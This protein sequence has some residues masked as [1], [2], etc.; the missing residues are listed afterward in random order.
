MR[1]TK[2]PVP[3]HAVI[4]G[5]GKTCASH[6][7]RNV[8]EAGLGRE[9]GL[10]TTRHAYLGGDVLPPPAWPGWREQLDQ[11]LERMR[12]AG[13]SAVVLTLPLFALGSAALAGLTF[14]TVVLTGC[15]DAV[16]AGE[17]AQ[18][19]ETQEGWWVCNIDDPICGRSF[20]ADSR[21]R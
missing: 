19:L 15:G 4:G 14:E 12:Q 10:I 17:V 1:W 9:Y 18:F 3:L 20:R 8:L 16:E 5:A 7:I 13:C 11:E 6:L 21:K 2:N